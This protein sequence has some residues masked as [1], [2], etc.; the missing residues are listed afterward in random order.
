MIRR[1]KLIWVVAVW[2]LIQQTFSITMPLRTVLMVLGLPPDLPRPAMGL[3]FIAEI[4]V[5]IGLVQLR[6]S[7]RVV[8][9]VLLG[10]G[11]FVGGSLLAQ[12][13]LSG[14]SPVTGHPYAVRTYILLPLLIAGDILAIGY[15]SRRQ[16]TDLS[17][18]FRDQIRNAQRENDLAEADAAILKNPPK[19]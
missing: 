4:V 15:L 16:F 1:P 3:I 10:L 11:A 7:A 6:K 8:A 9:T 17:R 19:L 18:Q 2:V 13:L 5:F 12:V 14:V